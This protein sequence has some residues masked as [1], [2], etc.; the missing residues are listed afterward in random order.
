MP[1]TK[2]EDEKP[3]Q[4][5]PEAENNENEV[6]DA[7]EKLKKDVLI[8]RLDRL[9]DVPKD[10]REAAFGICQSKCLDAFQDGAIS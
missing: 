9:H 3:Q 1:K 7:Q 10:R 6:L 2:K 4:S 5:Q 8:L